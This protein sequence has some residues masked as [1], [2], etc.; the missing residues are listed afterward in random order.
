[1]LQEGYQI[2]EQA[3]EEGEEDEFEVITATSNVFSS[4]VRGCT[5]NP[6]SQLL[7]ALPQNTPRACSPYVPDMDLSSQERR[8]A[9]DCHRAHCKRAGA[10]SVVQAASGTTLKAIAIKKCNATK[11]LALA[12]EFLETVRPGG[13]T[14]GQLRTVYPMVLSVADVLKISGLRLISWDA[15]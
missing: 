14:G 15:K 11:M 12:A 1:M 8:K 3:W 4:Q 10:R 7:V 5:F 13:W 9:K 2:S 6:L